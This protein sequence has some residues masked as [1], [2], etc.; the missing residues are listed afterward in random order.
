MRS[1]TGRLRTNHNNSPMPIQIME[2]NPSYQS[3]SSVAAARQFYN[4]QQQVAAC[5]ALAQGQ[6]GTYARPVLGQG[7][8]GRDMSFS[9]ANA[10][11]TATNN[12]PL[13]PPMYGEYVNSQNR[14]YNYESYCLQ[15]AHQFSQGQAAT[16]PQMQIP[17][18]VNYSQAQ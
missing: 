15:A 4:P 14:R 16:Q 1:S 7:T 6:S 5:N 17:S 10:G 18:Q 3:S 9:G 8:R 2:G 11:W 12:Q 13:I